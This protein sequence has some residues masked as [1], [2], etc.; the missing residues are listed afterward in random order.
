MVSKVR[1][2]TWLSQLMNDYGMIFV[3]LVL[4]VILALA[5]IDLQQAVGGTAGREVA[6]MIKK[7]STP[8][9]VMIATPQGK[10]DVEFTKGIK[11]ALAGTDHKVLEAVAGGPRDANKAL[12]RIVASGKKLDVIVVTAASAKWDPLKN[13]K[14]RKVMPSSYWWPDFLMPDNLVTIAQ[15]ITIIAIIAIGMTMVIVT[16]GIDLSVGSLIALSAVVTG[17]LIRDYGGGK[18]AGVMTLILCSLGGIAACG[19]AGFS[20][21]FL[22]AA[23]RLPP[24]IVTLAM[25]ML[26]RGV[27]NVI[28]KQRTIHEI[29]ISFETLGKGY[30]LGIPYSVLLMFGLYA[31]AYLIMGH[32][33]VGRQIYAVG[34]NEEAA[35]LSGVRVKRIQLIVYTVCG[36]LA[37]LGGVIMASQLR[38]AKA[39]YGNMEELTVIAAVV[40]GGTSLMGGEGKVLGTLI[41]AFIIGVIQNGMNLIHMDDKTQMIVLGSVIV[42]AVLLDRIKKGQV[43]WAEVKGV[44]KR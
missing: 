8:Q 28:S 38:S 14:I 40:V 37:G 22:V 33:T 13:S 5:T 34:G 32:T 21:G 23:F 15:R 24:F 4:M 3:L 9:M 16:A 36:L 39:S 26:I 27:A 17:V 44:F 43:H 7:S 20:S 31:L 30:I 42:I 35:R 18:D 19:F 29:P 1:N 41:G 6:K 12:K 2:N 10:L 25:M 11:E